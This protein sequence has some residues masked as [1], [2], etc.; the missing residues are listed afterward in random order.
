MKVIL[1][2]SLIVFMAWT[3]FWINPENIGPQLAVSTAS[4]LTLIAFQFSLVGMLPRVSY[5]TRVDLFLFGATMLVFLALGE[6]VFTS[7]IARADPA[8]KAQT[9]DFHARWSYALLFV[10]LLI[11]TLVV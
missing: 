2:V 7:R 3:V 4:V 6:A 1:P 9:I 8:S 11:S 10:L 5:L